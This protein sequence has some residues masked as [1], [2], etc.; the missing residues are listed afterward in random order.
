VGLDV[1]DCLLPWPSS[2]LLVTD[3]TTRTGFRLNI[4]SQLMPINDNGVVV[5]PGPWNRW[6]GFSPMTTLFAEF[7]SVIDSSRLATWHDPG[8]S[9]DPDSPTVLIDVDSGER[10]AHFVEIES[11][12][13][14]AADHTEMYIR[15]AARLAEGHHYAIGLRNLRNVDGTPA[16]VST[17]FRELRDQSPSL[18]EARRAELES[19]VFA[20]LAKAGIARATLQLAWDFRTGSGETAWG[21]LVAMRDAA[22][23]TPGMQVL[24]CSISSVATYPP[25]QPELLAEVHGQFTAPNFLTDDSSELN[26]DAD[27]RPITNGTVKASFTAIIPHSAVA[28]NGTAPLWVYG[29]GLFSN[30]NEL[31]R[32]FGLDTASQAG[33]VAVATDY[34]GLT[35]AETTDVVNAVLDL[36]QFPAILAR[37]RQSIINTLLLAR[38]FATSC[39]S[40]PQLQNLQPLVDATDLGYFGNSMGG[41]LGS[42]IAALSPDVHRFALGVGGIDFPVMMARTTRWPQLEAFYRI[43]YPRRLDRDLLMVMTANEW[44]L[45][46]SSAFAPH[47]LSDPLPGSQ[48]ASLL[49]QVGLYDADTTNVASEIAG[50]TL[51]LS[52]LSPSAH[53]VWGLPPVSGPQQ[54]AYVVYD[55]G[56]T[57][58]AEGT[59]PPAENGVHEGVRRDPRAQAQIVAFL[60]AGGQVVDTCGG[61][62]GPP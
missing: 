2:A 10:V 57:P 16:A 13:E 40:Q 6:D 19:D 49:F 60:R 41:T 27:G 30:Q 54:S 26:R 29:H 31:T 15:P 56:A 48:P 36:N 24:G 45:A 4:D 59:L 33:A 9:L 61:A 1:E 17:P 38:T 8:P 28:R 44:D 47:V 12:P 23:A 52:E 62:C 22:F 7:A 34:T 11:S 32:D 55:L 46:E 58:L 18:L 3:S 43:G 53:V 21:D 42:V 39:S 35:L 25:L 50:R 37:L 20:P 5:D 51:G 14:V